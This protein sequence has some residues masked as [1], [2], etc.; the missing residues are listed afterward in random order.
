[1]HRVSEA[2]ELDIYVGIQGSRLPCYVFFHCTYVDIE[3]QMQI[4]LVG[5]WTIS[6][7]VK[8]KIGNNVVK[9]PKKNIHD[10]V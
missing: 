3:I 8:I 9:I 10:D 7:G 6:K 4:S 1:M 5:R 2:I